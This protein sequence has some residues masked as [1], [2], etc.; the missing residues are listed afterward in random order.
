MGELGVLLVGVPLLKAAK[1]SEEFFG[2]KLQN[3]R[4]TAK[5]VCRLLN[6]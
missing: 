6:V 1:P 2:A 5:C 4:Q 3:K